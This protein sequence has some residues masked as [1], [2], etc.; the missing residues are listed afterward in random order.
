MIRTLTAIA[1]T[2]FLAVVPLA[3]AQDAPASA[4]AETEVEDDF[5]PVVIQVTGPGSLRKMADKAGY[6][7]TAAAE[8]LFVV[9]QGINILGAGGGRGATQ[10]GGPAIISGQW[11]ADAEIWLLV[12]GNVYGGG[13]GG[14]TSGSPVSTDGGKGGDA[15]AAQAP[16]TITVLKTGSIKGGGGGGGGAEGTPGYGGSGGGGGFPNGEPGLGGS[17]E[18][19]EGTFVGGDMGRPGT[20]AGGGLSGRRGNPGGKGGDAAMPGESGRRVGGSPGNAIRKNGHEVV[21]L[22]GGHIYGETF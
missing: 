21:V 8:Y 4:T 12:R 19:S 2:A 18:P 10:D 16:M 14:G 11:P 20:I 22:N 3:V 1:V 6:K 9:P 13:G 15:I 5:N 7:G 17:P